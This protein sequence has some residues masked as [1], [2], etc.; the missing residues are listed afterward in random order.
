[1]RPVNLPGY[2]NLRTTLSYGFPVQWLRSNLNV[3]AGV[4]TGRIPSVINGTRN[5][6]NGDSYDAGL[7]LGSNISESVDFKIGYTGCYN[8]SRNS[9]QIRTVDN[10]YVSQYLTAGLNFVL[11]RRIV[12]RGSADYNYYKGITDTFREERLIC[13]LQVGCKLFRKRMG[14]VTV[15]VNDLFDQNGTTF[16]RMVT[17]TYIRNVSNLGLGRYFLAQFSYNLR[18]FPRQGAAVTRIL[19][20]GAE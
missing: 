2:W 9:S 1:M 7:T 15:G 19:Q 13:N 16:R 3:R 4:T 20:Q 5:R 12:L 17:G 14:E 18:L 8:V 11:C 10:V 6:L